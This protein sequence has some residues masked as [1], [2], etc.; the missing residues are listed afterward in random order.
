MLQFLE[1]HVVQ[2]LED[3]TAELPDA[4]LPTL[5]Q[6]SSFRTFLEE[7][8]GHLM[9][10]GES[11]KISSSKAFLHLAHSYSNMGKVIPSSGLPIGS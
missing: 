4:P 3:L 5:K 10:S 8:A 11:L 9:V 7:H 6:E 2:A 1:L